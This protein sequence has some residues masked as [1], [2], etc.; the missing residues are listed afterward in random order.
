MIAIDYKKLMELQEKYKG[1][2]IFPNYDTMTSDAFFQHMQWKIKYDL[3]TEILC[4]TNYRVEE[5][6]NDNAEEPK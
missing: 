5:K 3:L 4:N 2:L 1:Y 6:E